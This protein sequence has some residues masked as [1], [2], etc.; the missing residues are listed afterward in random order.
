MDKFRRSNGC[1]KYFLKKMMTESDSKLG[2]EQLNKFCMSMSAMYSHKY[3]MSVSKHV[4]PNC[5]S[6]PLALLGGSFGNGGSVKT[7][8]SLLP[9]AT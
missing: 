6:L 8:P 9:K 5:N 3:Y 7:S 4:R 1:I 2:R